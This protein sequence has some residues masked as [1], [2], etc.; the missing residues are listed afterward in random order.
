MIIKGQLSESQMRRSQR[1]YCLYSL[2]NGFSYTCL[3][4]TVIILL[5]L[6]LKCQDYVISTIGAMLYFS[7]VILPC[8]KILA[9]RIGA[10]PSQAVFWFLRNCAALLVC[11]SVL[12]NHYDCHG[13]AVVTLLF[14]AF[15]F[16]GLRAAGVVMTKPLVGNI[17]TQNNRAA[18]L[19]IASAIS[20]IASVTALIGISIYLHYYK[21]IWPLAAVIVLGSVFG[22]TS[23]YFIKNIDE[24]DDLRDAARKPLLSGIRNAFSQTAIRQQIISGLAMTI[25][26][27][28]VM[29][30]SML[31]IKR[32]YGLTDKQALIYTIMQL[33]GSVVLSRLSIPFVRVF[34]P[35][36]ILMASYC[37]F[38]LICLVWIF[39][40]EK[41]NF[42][43]ISLVFLS[44]GGINVAQANSTTHYFLQT[45]SVQSQVTAS[46][47]IAVVS[48]GAGGLAA[49]LLSGGALKLLET[50][51]T[52][53]A[54]LLKY[55]YYFT[56]SILLLSPGFFLIKRLTPLPNE[57]RRLK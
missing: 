7:Y 9:A 45:V 46:I 20:H 27:I 18:F 22:F 8:G 24:T 50:F 29:P 55:K 21:G 10:A 51:F 2:L 56:A 35:R 16:Y 3:G 53:I 5:A 37:G 28:M 52:D 44:L 42:W 33:T 57:K 31:T 39:C 26:I 6:K 23:T 40:P 19:A 30:I 43:F 47:I 15:A 25:I 38:L 12:W 13:G 36:R 17:T 48:G 54:P 34:G 49:T 4:E 14:G 1:L 32:G 11:S 41:P